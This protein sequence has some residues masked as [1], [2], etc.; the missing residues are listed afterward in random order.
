MVAIAFDLY[1]IHGTL[2]KH[3]LKLSLTG[4][5]DGLLSAWRF[6]TNKRAFA[7]LAYQY[8]RTSGN[9]RMQIEAIA[10]EIAGEMIEEMNPSAAEGQP[11]Q[12]VQA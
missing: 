4:G 8:R 2:G 10:R 7:F 3:P 12:P 5:L 6:I 9:A 1:I 11:A